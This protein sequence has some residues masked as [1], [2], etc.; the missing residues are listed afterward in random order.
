MAL[1]GPRVALPAILMSLLGSSAEA[2]VYQWSAPVGVVASPETNAPPEAYLWIPP[3]CKAVNAVVLGQHNLLEEPLFEAPVFRAALAKSC[4]AEVWVTPMFDTTFDFTKGAGDTVT[5]MMARLA[6]TS[7]YQ[8]LATAPIIPVGHSA[9]ASFPWNFAAWAP[10]R[11]L[12]I[13]SLKGDAP[14]TTM[15]G[16]SKP[17][18]PWGDRTIDGIPGLMVMG[19]YEWLEGRLEPALAYQRAHPRAPISLYADAGR[20]HFDVSEDLA[21]YIGLF[22]EKAL[23]ARLPRAGSRPGD[24]ALTPVD[25]ARGWRADRWRGKAAPMAPAAPALSYRGPVEQSFW[26]FDAQMARLAERHYRSA[27]GKAPQLLGFLQSGAVVP[28]TNSH[29]QVELAFRPMPDGVSFTLAAAP[30]DRVPDGGPNPERWTGLP[31]GTPICH[32]RGPIVISRVTG[33]VIQTGPQSWR[34]AFNRVGFNNRRRSGDIWFVASQAGDHRY[35]SAVQ[36]AIMKVPPTNASGA[37]QKIRFTLPEAWSLRAG[38][39]LRLKATSDAGL[40]V[41][42]YVKQGPAEIVGDQLR[43]DAIPMRATRPIKVT[44]VAWQYGVQGLIKS[45]EPE[46]RTI[47]LTD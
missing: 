24:L 11:T 23:H 16:S 26:Y 46:V 41:Q 33:P 1:F 42:Y 29:A 45:A 7:G 44:I 17:N 10:A 43:F 25:P 9:A 8:E 15:T 28:Q 3:R 13:I 32:A 2:S 30:L 20:G 22:I 47:A 12:A 37:P 4:V 40:P 19:E 36:Q 14:L 21:R 5:T 39:S 18:P 34:L 6:R 38:R 27:A 35:K 31:P